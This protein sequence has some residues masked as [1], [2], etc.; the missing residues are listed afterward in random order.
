MRKG[1]LSTKRALFFFLLSIAGF[2]AWLYL[3]TFAGILLLACRTGWVV[4]EA[5]SL[6]HVESALMLSAC[7]VVAFITIYSVASIASDITNVSSRRSEI[8]ILQ[9]NRRFQGRYIYIVV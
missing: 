5:D 8:S 6:M 4:I 9:E 7:I 3:A 2:V 1:L